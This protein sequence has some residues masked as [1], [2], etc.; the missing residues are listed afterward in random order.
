MSFSSEKD[1][2]S[3]YR[4]SNSILNVL[5]KPPEQISLKLLYTN[6]VSIFTYGSEVKEFNCSEMNDCNV[7]VNDAIRKIFMFNRWESTRELRKSFGYTNL[8]ELFPHARN[9]FL[10]K[11][12]YSNNAEIRHLYQLSH[13]S[14]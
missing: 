2:R 12:P 14:S 4:A 9:H 3:F 1:L 5:N 6:C 13:D 7:A 10:A 11:L 8:Y